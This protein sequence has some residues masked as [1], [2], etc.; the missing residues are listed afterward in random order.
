MKK[1]KI[2]R[3]NVGVFIDQND[4][5]VDITVVFIAIVAFRSKMRLFFS[6]L[7]VHHFVLKRWD[8]FLLETISSQFRFAIFTGHVFPSQR[9]ES[10]IE[11]DLLT[12]KK[13]I[14][15]LSVTS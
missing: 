2:C 9:L 1:K 12:Q 15:Y 8:L 14:D 11:A 6:S 10:R 5:L 13:E 3:S 4:I 7:I